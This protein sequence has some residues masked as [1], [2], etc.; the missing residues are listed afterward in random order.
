MTSTTSG[1]V[2]RIFSPMGL[3]LIPTISDGETN[4][5][6]AARLSFS[7][8]SSARP[9]L[10]EALILGTSRVP[11]LEAVPVLILTT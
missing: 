5:L 1:F 11:L 8:A 6:Q 9:R 10:T 3:T 7:P 2:E 4:C